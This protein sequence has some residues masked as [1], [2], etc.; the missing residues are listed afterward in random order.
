MIFNKMIMKLIIIISTIIK[1]MITT[2][3]KILIT[4]K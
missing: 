2:I 1:M 4:M 3:I